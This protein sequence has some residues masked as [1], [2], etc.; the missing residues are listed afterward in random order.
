[1]IAMAKSLEKIKDI[2]FEIDIVF[3]SGNDEL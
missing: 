2:C 3:G 1:M